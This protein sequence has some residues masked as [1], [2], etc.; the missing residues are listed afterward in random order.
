MRV[1]GS[2]NTKFFK[3]FAN[4]LTF[5]SI[6]LRL[7]VITIRAQRTDVLET[8]KYNFRIAHRQNDFHRDPNIEPP[9]GIW[10]DCR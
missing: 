7:L 5:V 2:D 8:S 3:I 9:S 4:S 1:N 10:F 6:R